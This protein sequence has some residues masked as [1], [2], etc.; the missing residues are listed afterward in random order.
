MRLTPV[1]CS[2][3]TEPDKTIKFY[4]GGNT[5]ERR[6]YIMENLVCDSSDF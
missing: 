2:E 5:P 4:M 6:E 3:D 1:I